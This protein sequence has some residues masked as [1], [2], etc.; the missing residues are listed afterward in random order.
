MSEPRIVGGARGTV[1]V[2]CRRLKRP[3]PVLDHVACSYC[4]G[5]ERDVRT[6]D[7]ER[8]CDFQEGKDPIHFGFPER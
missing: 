7:H 3:L 5:K 4:F 6:G 8:F 1:F 2:Y